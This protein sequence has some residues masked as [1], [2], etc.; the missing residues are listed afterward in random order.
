MR[1]TAWARTIACAEII[2]ANSIASVKTK[3]SI[4]KTPSATSFLRGGGT[5]LESS[6]SVTPSADM[7]RYGLKVLRYSTRASPCAS[8]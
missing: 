8:L 5:G 3:S 4:P 1:P 2:P 6:V 7:D